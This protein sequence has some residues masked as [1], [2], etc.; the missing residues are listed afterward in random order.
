MRVDFNILNMIDETLNPSVEKSTAEN[1]VVNSESLNVNP[2]GNAPAV[3]EA[4]AIGAAVA[5]AGEIVD[6][7][8][9]ESGESGASEVSVADAETGTDAAEE[10]M[11]GAVISDEELKRLSS[12]SLKEIV[13]AFR[14]LVENGDIMELNRQAEYIKAT[15]YKVLKEEKIASGYHVLPGSAEYVETSEPEDGL[16]AVSDTEPVSEEPEAV[17]A[18]DDEEVSVNPF[19]EIERAFKDLYANYKAPTIKPAAPCISRIWSARSRPI[20]RRSWRLSRN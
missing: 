3:E 6:S 2:S 1:S 18:K 13:E 20:W 12:K 9:S 7:V 4:A 16:E 10:E 8:V 19:I 15:F 14:N 17:P 5:A 11:R